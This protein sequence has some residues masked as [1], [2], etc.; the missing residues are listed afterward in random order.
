M[1]I[2]ISSAS[3]RMGLQASL[4]KRNLP[5]NQSWVYCLHLGG[6]SIVLLMPPL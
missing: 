2:W 1:N 4:A 6:V 3:R 5:K